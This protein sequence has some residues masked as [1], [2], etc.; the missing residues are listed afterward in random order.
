MKNALARTRNVVKYHPIP[1]KIRIQ[2]MKGTGICTA[3]NQDSENFLTPARQKPN[4]RFRNK[5]ENPTI[6][7]SCITLIVS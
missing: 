6:H 2:T 7:K 4:G 5:I 3:R 1:A